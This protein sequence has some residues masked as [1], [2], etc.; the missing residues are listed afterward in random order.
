M[1]YRQPLNIS[2]RI[3]PGQQ[4]KKLMDVNRDWERIDEALMEALHMPSDG[5]ER[6]HA[7]NQL[8]SKDPIMKDLTDDEI[9]ERIKLVYSREIL[10]D[11][12]LRNFLK[13][14]AESNPPTSK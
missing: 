2:L 7:L 9:L 4:W 14:E 11:L 3:K 10:V 1:I 6:T 13:L 8:R 12:Y 5:T